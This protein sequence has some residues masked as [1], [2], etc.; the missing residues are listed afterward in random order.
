M[1]VR[2][3]IVL[4]LIAIMFACSAEA[5]TTVDKGAQEMNGSVSG[6]VKDAAGAVLQGASIVLEP[7]ATTTASNSLGNYLLPN[8]KPGTYTVTITYVGF[9]PSVSSVTVT[10]GKTT[11]LDATLAVSSASQE[12]VVSANVEGDAASIN[13]Q[14]VSENILNVETEAQI[15]SLP[16]ANIADAVG[17][18]PGVTLQRN[19]G[20]GQYV[21]IRGTEPRL[22]NTT[23]DGVIVPGPSGSAGGPRYDSCRSGWCGRNQQNTVSKPGRGRDRRLGKSEHQAGYFEPAHACL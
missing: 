2:S 23:I 6:T 19:E 22:S 20:E 9:R 10:A 18:M 5:E 17:R 12:I 21:Q 8:V 13:E 16:N 11:S 15:Q 4:I 3:I 1:P 7:T 14:R